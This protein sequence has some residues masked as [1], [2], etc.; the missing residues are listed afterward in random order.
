MQFTNIIAPQLHTG[1]MMPF[2]IRYS[3][4][5]YRMYEFSIPDHE[6]VMDLPEP[7]SGEVKLGNQCTKQNAICNYLKQKYFYN[8]YL[9]VYGIWYMVYSI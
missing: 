7:T 6:A 4:V 2:N 3:T 5:P 8:E 1:Q 9:L